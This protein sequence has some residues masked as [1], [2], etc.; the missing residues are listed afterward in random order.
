MTPY[1]RTGMIVYLNGQYVA[2]EEAK[3]SVWD[4]GYLNGDGIYT[5]LRLYSG[6]PLDLRAH[7]RR[8]RSH[9]GE[10]DLPVPVSEDQ[11]RKVA[12]ELARINGLSAVDGRLRIT[13]SRGG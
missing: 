1:R 4:G 12:G 5:T 11:L 9:A 8:L 3:I 10:L 13:I 7:H 6:I 2:A